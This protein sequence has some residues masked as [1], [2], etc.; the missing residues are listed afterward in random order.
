M[1]LTHNISPQSE[2]MRR[3]IAV[4]RRRLRQTRTTQRI[5]R[6]SAAPDDIIGGSATEGRELFDSSVRAAR[7]EEIGREH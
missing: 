5:A 1:P 7:G 6:R 4:C 2:E 3:R